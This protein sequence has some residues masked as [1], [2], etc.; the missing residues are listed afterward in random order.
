[1]FIG[2]FG[3]VRFGAWPRV[4]SQCVS[5]GNDCV[6]GV[7]QWVTKLKCD[8]FGSLLGLQCV[9]MG[10]PLKVN[11]KQGCDGCS[12]MDVR[13][14]VGMSVKLYLWT[15][16]VLGFGFIFGVVVFSVVNSFIGGCLKL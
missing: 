8:V 10:F 16:F 12:S 3:S 7:L 9:S 13:F 2:Q 1:M 15:L 14:Q 5:M 6:M 11:G 4:Q